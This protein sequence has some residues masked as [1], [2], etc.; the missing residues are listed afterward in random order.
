[1][2]GADGDGQRVTAGLLHKLLYVL[3]TGVGRIRSGNLDLVLNAGQGAQLS[4][5]HNAVVMGI[6]H[7]LTGDGDVLLKGLGGS[8]DHNGGKAVVDAGFAG[9]KGVAVIQVQADGQAGLD[10]GS[11]HQLYKIGAVG[12]GTGALG[13]LKDH[14]GIALPG[15]LGDALND[16]HI[17]DVKGADGI[18]AV[19]GLFEHFR[20]CD[21]RHV[22]TLLMN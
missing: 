7:H 22:H 20:G 12:I 5:D 9:L 18:A 4:L 13:H 1:M 21:N 15:S 14:R 8:V 19:V 10:L 16:L 3:G 6:L 17:V 11:L 2:G